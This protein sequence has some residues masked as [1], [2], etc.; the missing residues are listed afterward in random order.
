MSD[1]HDIEYF[2]KIKQEKKEKNKKLVRNILIGLIFIVGVAIYFVLP[3]SKIQSISVTGNQNF[4]SQQII[5]K[6]NINLE[7]I[8]LLRPSILLQHDLNNTH[9]FQDVSISKTWDGHVSIHVVENRL[10]FYQVGEEQTTFFDEQ[11]NAIVFPTE[12]LNAKKSRIPVLNE[13]EQMTDQIKN[14]LINRLSILEPSVLIEISEITH[15]PLAFDVENFLFTMSG[16]SQIFIQANLDDLV[17]VGANYHSFSV[18]T[19]YECSLIQFIN[20]EN[21]AIVRNC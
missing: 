4:T 13:S 6:V 7:D 11:G 21:R 20:S 10:L 18:N 3:V 5:D 14:K 1:L 15:Q 2:Q 16:A 12:N 17:T 9:L 8:S 19:R